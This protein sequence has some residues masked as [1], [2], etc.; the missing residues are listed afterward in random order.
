MTNFISNVLK[1]LSGTVIAQIIGIILIPIITR[2]YS[3]GDYGIFQLFLSISSILAIIS[4]YSYQ[5]SIMLPKEDEDSVNIVSLCIILVTLN[6]FFFGIIIFFFSDW[7]GELLNAPMLSQYLLLMPFFLFFN[8]FNQVMNYW[9]S[10]KLRYVIIAASQVTNSVSGKVLQVTSGIVFS[11]SP[12]GLIT[13]ILAGCII[14]STVMLKGISLDFFLLHN[15]NVQKIKEMALRYKKF[16][17]ITSFSSIINEM[18]RQLPSFFL[19]YFFCSQVVGFYS[20][21]YQLI[22]LPSSLVGAAIGQAFFQR[23]CKEKNDKGTI[24]SL[25]QDVHKK[26]IKIYIFPLVLLYFIADELINVFLGGIWSGSGIYVMILIP[27]IFLMFI[28]SPL[29][30]IFSVLEKQGVNLFFDISLLM[31]RIC[32]LFFGGMYRDPILTIGLYS[33]VGA[34]F[35]L[36]MNFWILKISGINYKDELIYLIK[37]ILFAIIMCFPVIWVKYY[38][39]SIIMI[40]SSLIMLIIYTLIIIHSDSTFKKYIREFTGKFF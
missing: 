14:S 27:W 21:A 33:T 36:L 5:L 2:L 34:L 29:T 37:M 40:V 7:I 8:G 1:L 31:S 23:A 22:S 17:L 25:V 10:R 26:L 6:S 39:S 35:N 20:I 30:Y 3:P 9:L 24:K 4:C 32:V 38:F 18:S 12:F 13:G 15:I 19:I 11:P 16:P 28:S